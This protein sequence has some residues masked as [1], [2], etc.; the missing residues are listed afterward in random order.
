[1]L[2]GQEYEVG[3]SGRNAMQ[4]TLVVQQKG[5]IDYFTEKGD[6]VMFRRALSFI[7]CGWSAQILYSFGVN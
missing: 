5:F 6:L 4:L 7:L 3:Q 2:L 1:M